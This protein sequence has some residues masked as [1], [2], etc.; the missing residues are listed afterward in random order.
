MFHTCNFKCKILFLRI[1]YWF[2]DLFEGCL[3]FVHQRGS[4][5]AFESRITPF[6]LF[7][8]YFLNALYIWIQF[9]TMV[10]KPSESRVPRRSVHLDI[11]TGKPGPR[12]NLYT[13]VLGIEILQRPFELTLWW[14]INKDAVWEIRKHHFRNK[15]N[16]VVRVRCWKIGSLSLVS[17][18]MRLSL[19]LLRAALMWMAIAL[20]L[21]SEGCRC[22]S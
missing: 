11:L 12:H 7:R 17:F 5:Q 22:L 9:V 20:L 18:R 6:F 14:Q 13:W 3:E 16:T 1:L 4:C 21:H 2:L 19:C 8:W 15:R 10:T